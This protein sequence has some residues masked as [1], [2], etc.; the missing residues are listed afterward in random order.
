MCRCYTVDWL[1][2]LVCSFVPKGV[3]NPDCGCVNH[4]PPI[5]WN[6][7]KGITYEAKRR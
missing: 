2:G 1:P 6:E 7:L 3:L 4:V 5:P